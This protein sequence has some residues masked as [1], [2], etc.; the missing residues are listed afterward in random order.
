MRAGCDHATVADHHQLV[1]PERVPYVG[2]D[3]GERGRVGGVT[4]EDPHRHRPTS[5][6]GEQAVLDL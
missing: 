5:R 6:V 4:G 3:L 2:D 1:Q